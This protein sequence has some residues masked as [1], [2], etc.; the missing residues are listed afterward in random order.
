LLSSAE[1]DAGFLSV[2]RCSPGAGLFPQDKTE[3][4]RLEDD[5]DDSSFAAAVLVGATDLRE[6][7]CWV[8]VAVT[9]SLGL[10]SLGLL[11]LGLLNLLGSGGWLIIRY[12]EAVFML[13]LSLEL[14]IGL[15]EGAGLLHC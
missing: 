5:E 1:V 13:Q 6:S 11:T 8:G 9:L 14:V 2:E 3:G 15:G 10:L 7:L 12:R 4:K